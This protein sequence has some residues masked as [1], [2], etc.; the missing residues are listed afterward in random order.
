VARVSGRLERGGYRSKVVTIARAFGIKG[1][2][3]NLS[4]GRVKVIAEGEKADLERFAE[5]LKMRNDIIHVARIETEYS[6]PI[7]GYDNFYRLIGEGETDD[8]LDEWVKYLKELLDVTREG[9][10]RIG[11][12]SQK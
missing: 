6:T 4:D 10:N 1:S 11:S 3:Q 8:L 12:Q 9:F 5:A 2:I 7:G